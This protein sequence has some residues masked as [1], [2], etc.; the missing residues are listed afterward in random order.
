MNIVCRDLTGAQL[1]SVYNKA[2]GKRAFTSFRFRNRSEAQLSGFQSLRKSGPEKDLGQTLFYSSVDREPEG[3]AA[4]D[5]QIGG[6]ETLDAGSSSTAYDGNPYKKAE[7]C[8]SLSQKLAYGQCPHTCKF[9]L[10]L[11]PWLGAFLGGDIDKHTDMIVKCKCW[12]YISSCWL[13]HHCL[14]CFCDLRLCASCSRWICSALRRYRS[15][16]R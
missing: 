2:K 14:H 9:S 7:K 5:G 6:A 8:N 15:W 11:I 16:Q 12:W 10:R 3:D 1:F 13:H 4:C